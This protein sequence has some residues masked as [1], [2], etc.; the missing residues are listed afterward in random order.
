MRVSGRK[1]VFGLGA[2]GALTVVA[3]LVAFRGV[4]WARF[5]ANTRLMDGKSNVMRFAGAVMA[6]AEQ[7][8]RVPDSSVSVPPRL[9][10]VGGKKFD[11]TP[12]DWRADETL[13]CAGWSP[14][15]PQSFRY[16]WLKTGDR[17]GRTR[18]EADFDGDGVAEAVYEQE[19][20]CEAGGARVR[21]GPGPLH[22]IAQ[23]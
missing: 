4:G 8:G 14:D 2:G 19:I 7:S 10:D 22:D 1:L 12:A 21:C 17:A 15:G 6:C 23:R 20:A 18:A 16:R 9:S 13:R 11:G 5:Q 3:I